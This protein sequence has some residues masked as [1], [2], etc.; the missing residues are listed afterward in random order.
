MNTNEFKAWFDGFN[1][2]VSVAPSEEQ[3]NR[4][5]KIVRG[6]DGAPVTE[7][8]FYDHYWAPYRP[9]FG[10]QLGPVRPG[11]VYCSTSTGAAVCGSVEGCGEAESVSRFY[12][13]GALEAEGV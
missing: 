8:R 13:L 5:K 3:W 12:A 9:Y 4:I 1:E 6:L 11:V 10:D 2:G 7:R